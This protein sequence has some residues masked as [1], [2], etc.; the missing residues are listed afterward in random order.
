MY[1]LF[2][3]TTDFSMFKKEFHFKN[4][5]KMGCARKRL[6]SLKFHTFTIATSFVATASNLFNNNFPREGGELRRIPVVQIGSSVK[7]S[8]YSV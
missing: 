2:V 1:F 8:A 3:L 7:M 6:R 5:F 4:S